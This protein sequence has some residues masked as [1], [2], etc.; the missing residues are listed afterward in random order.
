MVLDGAAGDRLDVVFDQAAGG[1]AAGVE[2]THGEL[3]ARLA[4]GL[5]GDDADGQAFLDDLV[6]GHVDAIA[7]GADA[8]R[9]FAGQRRADADAFELQFLDLVGDLVGDDLV[10]GDDRFI[11][12]RIADGVAGRSADDHVLQF[13]FDGLA[14]VDGGLGDAVERLAVDLVDDDVLRH[15]GE[16]AGEVA[17]VGG[18]EGGVGQ[19]LAGAVRG[20]EIFQ[21]AEGLR[22]NWP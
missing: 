4:D 10:F 7:A 13:D 2:R 5:G 15:V 8:A 22:G 18:L 6:G 3:R 17:G 9:A 12:D 11:G 1:H 21:H 19:T 16:L 14:L 20:G